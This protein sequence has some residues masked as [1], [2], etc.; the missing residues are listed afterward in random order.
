MTLNRP[1]TTRKLAEL[2]AKLEGLKHELSH[3][4]A[5]SQVRQPLEKHRSQIRR[6]SKR[7]EGRLAAMEEQ[8]EDH[9][10]K[11][12]PRSRE[13]EQQLL[14]AHTIWGFFRNKL[15]LRLDPLSHDFLGACDEFAWAC[16]EP[17]Q[18]AYRRAHPDFDNEQA[19]LRLKEPP[20][21]FLNGGWSPYAVGRDASFRTELWEGG[22]SPKK[23]AREVFEQVPFPMIG[24]PWYQLSHLPDA[25]VIGHEMGH[26]VEW[27]FELSNSLHDVLS[28]A[29]IAAERWPAWDGWFPEVFADFFGCLAGGPAFAGSLMDFLLAKADSAEDSRKGP[30]AWGS[31]P[32][33]WLRL[34]LVFE[35][36][37]VLDNQLESKAAIADLRSECADLG[38][39]LSTEHESL[40]KDAKNLIASLV[41]K[42]FPTLDNQRLSD[43]VVPVGYRTV[44]VT[45]LNFVENSILDSHDAR[46]LFAAARWIHQSTDWTASEADTR[47][48]QIC[49]HLVQNIPPGV[50]AA[51]SSPVSISDG[52][53]E[54]L[55]RVWLL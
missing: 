44:C 26:I 6:I 4:R 28:E 7:I 39:T 46:L 1:A 34:D 35:A 8:M 17:L 22:W 47:Y 51:S 32:F 21:V 24:V 25:L 5:R 27:D 40:R 12:L 54:Q 29:G 36:A 41:T 50:R 2:Q 19:A 45:A 38:G 18:E 10:L 16:Y 23:G 37:Q 49:S 14:E 33:L 53:E 52:A 13:M 31:Y 3:W 20:L 42:K 30:G 11:A 15:A 9:G 43:V 48:R 55:G